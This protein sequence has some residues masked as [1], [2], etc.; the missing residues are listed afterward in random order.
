MI[1][2]LY[3]E[4]WLGFDIDLNP[5][6]GVNRGLGGGMSVKVSRMLEV[7]SERYLVG[8][9]TLSDVKDGELILVDPLWFTLDVKAPP[10]EGETPEAYASRQKQYVNE[11]A[12]HLLGR[13]NP[14]ALCCSE[15]ELM[16][17]GKSFRRRVLGRVDVVTSNCEFQRDVFSYYGVPRPLILTDPVPESLFTPDLREGADPAR[18]VVASGQIAWYKNSGGMASVLEMVLDAVDD[19]E[20]VYL[21]SASLWDPADAAAGKK[22]EDQMRRVCGRDNVRTVKSRDVALELSK[23][24]AF[25]IDTYHDT[26]SLGMAEAM[27]CGTPVVSGPHGLSRERLCKRGDTGAE[28]AAHLEAVLTMSGKEWW[29]LAERTAAEAL[30]K[31][32]YA[33][34][35]TQF[36]RVIGELS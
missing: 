14:I 18:R 22:Y 33:A 15:L 2:C 30:S 17:W 11:R 36:E 10:Q 35:H 31:F 9:G 34:F 4:R 28:Q 8:A 19:A 1:R 23:A 25:Y 16:R 27:M 7:L 6:K 32:S 29:D 12:D 20:A 5:E 21:G 3:P 26:F 13:S 24:K